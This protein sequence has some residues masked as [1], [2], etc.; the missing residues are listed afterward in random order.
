MSTTWVAILSA[1]P[2]LLV[3]IAS[4]VNSVLANKKATAAV[5]AA[6]AV[7]PADYTQT[8]IAQKAE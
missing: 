6:N 3:A 5:Q 4:F 1:L 2:A 8:I 7:K